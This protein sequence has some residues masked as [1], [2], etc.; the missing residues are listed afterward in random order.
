MMPEMMYAMTKAQV[1]LGRL[2]GGGALSEGA[3]LQGLEEGVRFRGRKGERE[4]AT[5][6]AQR[7]EQVLKA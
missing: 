3:A 2:E 7:E 6:P 5:R 4:P 1:E